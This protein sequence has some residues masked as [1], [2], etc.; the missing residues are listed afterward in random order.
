MVDGSGLENRQA[1]RPRGFE[2]HPLRQSDAEC[3]SRSAATAVRWTRRRA[4]FHRHRFPAVPPFLRDSVP[5]R[6]IRCEVR[7][8]DL[9]AFS[10]KQGSNY[11]NCEAADHIG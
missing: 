10:N 9:H 1:E 2:S 3:G 4:S 5:F 11:S 7:I 8:P 6:Q